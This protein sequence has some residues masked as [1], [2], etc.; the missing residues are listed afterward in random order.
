MKRIAVLSAT[1]VS[2]GACGGGSRETGVIEG[3]VKLGPIMPVC[4]V[5]VPCDGVYKGAKVILQTQA[6]QVVQ[7]ATADDRGEFRMGTPVGDFQVR[8]E[9]PGPMPTCTVADVSVRARETVQVAIDCDS[10]IR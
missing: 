6:G 3:E 4:Q 2:L 10:G 9:V 1:L 5:G 7:R 8:V